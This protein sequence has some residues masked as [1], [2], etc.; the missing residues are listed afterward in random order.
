MATQW[1]DDA[2]AF[3]KRSLADT[4]YVYCWVDGIH[5]KVRLD[6]D[7]VCLLVMIGVREDGTKE[8]IALGRGDFLAQAEPPAVFATLTAPGFRAVHTTGGKDLGSNSARG[9]HAAG[10]GLRCPHGNPLGFGQSLLRAIGDKSLR[11]H[12]TVYTMA[13]SVLGALAAGAVDAAFGAEGL[14][15][16]GKALAVLA[17]FTGTSLGLVILGAYLAGRPPRISMVLPTPTALG[18]EVAAL[19]VGVATGLVVLLAPYL[20]PVVLVL[21]AVLHRSALTRHLQAA[22]TIDAKT[23]LLTCT[24]WHQQAERLLRVTRKALP[25][26]AVLMIDLDH[27]K[28]IND[29]YGHLVGDEVLQAVAQRLTRQLRS[30]DLLGRFDGEEFVVLLLGADATTGHEVAERMR[31]CLHTICLDTAPD[32]QVSAL[33]GLAVYP[34][35]GGTLTDVLRTADHTVY[36]AKDASRDTTLTAHPTRH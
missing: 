6:Q 23:G 27:F 3:N 28:V 19:V 14:A 20:A 34:D 36:A 22:A 8:L 17:V 32:L 7:K 10:G 16:P 15:S 11:L 35:H 26:S 21:V 18:D 33:M 24:A 31:R 1:Q 30:G 5:L 4:D 2:T 13:A 25:P 12:R 29:S 9:C